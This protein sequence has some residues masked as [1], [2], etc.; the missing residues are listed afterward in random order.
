[1]HS[2]KKFCIP[3]LT[4]DSGHTKGYNSPQKKIKLLEADI[5]ALATKSY[6]RIWRPGT[7]I[8]WRRMLPPSLFFGAVIYYEELFF[9]LYSFGSLSWTGALFTLLFTIPFSLLLGQF[10]AGVHWRKGRRRLF[11]CVALISLWIGAQAIYF[12]LFKTFLTIFSLT[13]LTMVAGAFGGMAVGEIAMNWFPVLMMSLPLAAAW[14]F[15]RKILPEYLCGATGRV[16]WLFLSLGS[17]L[18]TV[19]LVLLCGGGAL[20]LRYI[21]LWTATPDLEAR[22]FGVLTQTTLE[23]RRVVF[24]IP[25]DHENASGASSQFDSSLVGMGDSHED[26]AP[27]FSPQEYNA[28]EL[29][30]DAL[31]AQ[32]TQEGNQI[33]LDMHQYFSAL[34]PTSKHEWT[35]YFQGKNLV[36]IVAEGFCTLAIDQERTP[37]LWML[38]NGGFQFEHFY[39]PLWGIST[40]DGEY[41]TTTGLIP[42][43][44]VWS[45]SQSSDNYMPFAMG[46]QL[47]LLGYRTLAYHN[48]T[49]TYYDRDQSYPNMGYEYYALGKGL[50]LEETWPPSDLEMMEK[51]VPQFV[52][53][54]QFAVYCLTVSGHLNYNLEENAMCRRHWAQVKDLP[55]SESVRCYLACQ[56][57]L[58]LA[59]QSL[60]EQLDAAGR[61]EDTVIVLSGD[62]YPYGLN[63]EQYSELLGHAVNPTLEIYEN[64]LII[65]NSEMEQPIPIENYCAS[66]DILP[67][68][69]NL[70]GL[71][72]DSRLMAGRDILSDAPG[73]VIFSDYSFISDLG[74]YNAKLDQF[75]PRDGVTLPESY[76]TE[77]L[78]EVQ[79]RVAYSAAILD[80]DYYRALFVPQQE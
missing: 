45:Y 64:T 66:L 30:F 4:F 9:K 17:Y 5:M 21:Y 27:V 20:S 74:E 22:N 7:S 63:D 62:H 58:E 44:G 72:Y 13:K 38:A 37:T 32:A 31:I 77:T 48:F 67:T 11:L 36:W 60:I 53:E 34:Q 1:M 10:C 55:Y 6:K 19:A 50:E 23:I 40:S 70:F 41:V 46:N 57:E 3:I 51:I 79:N 15:R 78:A 61:L 25:T 2:S 68:L 29:D 69:S 12:R 71:D 80:L 76:L 33:T 54:E 47:G 8:Q 24:G 28:M 39:A 16:R 75:F 59:M 56:M 49:Y 35:G 26:A 65:W 42:K 73:L 14:I 43:S 52:G 18:A